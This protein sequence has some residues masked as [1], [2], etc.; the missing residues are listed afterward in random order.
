MGKLRRICL[1]VFST[2]NVDLENIIPYLDI[3]TYFDYYLI[4]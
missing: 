4:R 3:I 1:V 2:E